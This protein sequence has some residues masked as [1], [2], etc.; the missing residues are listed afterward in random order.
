MLYREVLT[1]QI[2]LG[3]LWEHL[4]SGC[5]HVFEDFLYEDA[6]WIIFVVVLFPAFL[7]LA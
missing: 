6:L 1:V 3:W 5:K 2:S 7:P 4:Y